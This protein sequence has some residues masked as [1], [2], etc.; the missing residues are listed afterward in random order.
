MSGSEMQIV[1]ERYTN[2]K[3]FIKDKCKNQNSFIETFMITP[4][5]H[6]ILTIKNKMDNGINKEDCLTEIF[7]NAEVKK[8]DF[9]EKDIKKLV[10]YMEYFADVC[11]LIK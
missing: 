7:T 6:F 2:F 1:L 4:L 8:E 3:K 5:D 9:D 11:M 10:S